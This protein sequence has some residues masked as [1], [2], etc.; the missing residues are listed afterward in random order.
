MLF[1]A[2]ALSPKDHF[3]SQVTPPT[4]IADLTLSDQ[5]TLS[6]LIVLLSSYERLGTGILM[7]YKLET[8]FTTTFHIME[9]MKLIAQWWNG[10]SLGLWFKKTHA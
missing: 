9:A 8:D 5:Q 2:I 7:R 1:S 6:R 4:P 10:S 3:A